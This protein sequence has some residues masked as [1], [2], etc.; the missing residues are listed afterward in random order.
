[1]KSLAKQGCIQPRNQAIPILHKEEDILWEK[2][3][4]GEDTPE[5]LVNTVMYLIGIHFALHGGEEHMALK[6]RAFAQI[7]LKYDELD[8]KFL[9]YQPNQ[10]KN[11]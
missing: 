11:N 4:L 8:M 7:K 1:M 5:I 3:V 10:L 9:E 2:G 6:V